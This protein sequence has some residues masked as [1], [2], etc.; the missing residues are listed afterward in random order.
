MGHIRKKSNV[1]GFSG[2]HLSASDDSKVLN[3]DSGIILIQS[4]RNMMEDCG[5]YMSGSEKGHMTGS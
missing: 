5:L 2:G 1:Y 3:K 4:Y